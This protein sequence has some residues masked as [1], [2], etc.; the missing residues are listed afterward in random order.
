MPLRITGLL[1]GFT[2]A[3]LVALKSD[4]AAGTAKSTTVVG[5]AAQVLAVASKAAAAILAEYTFKT[6]PAKMPGAES[7]VGVGV[8]TGATAVV[9]PWSDVGY[10]STED[11]IWGG[12]GATCADSDSPSSESSP[13]TPLPR[14]GAPRQHTHQS[15]PPSSTVVAMGQ[16][17]SGAVLALPLALV[18]DFWLV[19]SRGTALFRYVKE[20][21]YCKTERSGLRML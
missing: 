17:I 1:F 5:V 19:P 11:Q 10:L 6:S 9:E 16:A 4:F 12:G 3:L 8:G 21:K 2:G 18:W 7:G 13:V 14:S 15:R 20:K